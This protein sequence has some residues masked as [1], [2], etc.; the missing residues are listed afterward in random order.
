MPPSN[1]SLFG[2]YASNA[3][4][5]SLFGGLT[6]QQPGSTVVRWLECTQ[7]AAIYNA[8]NFSLTG[9][10]LPAPGQFPTQILHLVLSSLF[11]KQMTL[12][13]CRVLCWRQATASTSVSHLVIIVASFG[14]VDLCDKLNCFGYG[15]DTPEN[16]ER[17]LEV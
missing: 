15:I 11:R 3:T 7:F 4:M 16:V 13:F 9:A 1:S 2:F 14:S 6:F 8:H 10:R 12:P 17:I 5:P